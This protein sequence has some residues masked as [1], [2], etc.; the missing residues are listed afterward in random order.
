MNTYSEKREV[1]ICKL[2]VISVTRNVLEGSSKSSKMQST[3]LAYEE[4]FDLRKTKTGNSGPFSIRFHV[5]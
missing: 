4:N 3:R 2:L 5:L 1:S